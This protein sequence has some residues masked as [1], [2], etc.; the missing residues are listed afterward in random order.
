MSRRLL[1]TLVVAAAGLAVAGAAL[2]QTQST[3]KLV[4]TVGPGYTIK[5]TKAGV[6]VKSLKAGTYKFVISDKSPFH[7]FTVEKETGSEGREA[8][9]RDELHRLE[10]D[11]A[12]PQG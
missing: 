9:D 11:D 2:S 1:A 4:G 7:N 8:P 3:A 10:I 6:K 12:D 5:L